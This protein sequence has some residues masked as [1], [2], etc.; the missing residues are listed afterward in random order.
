MLLLFTSCSILIKNP[1]Y[2][3]HNGFFKKLCDNVAENVTVQVYLPT[4]TEDI[5]IF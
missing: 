5:T 4:V 3:I 1:C 2:E